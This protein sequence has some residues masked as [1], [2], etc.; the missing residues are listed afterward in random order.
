MNKKYMQGK[1]GK[2]SAHRAAFVG[3][4][5]Y[6][7]DKNLKTLSRKNLIYSFNIQL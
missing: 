1:R 2:Q 4:N 7:W 6:S 5:R 3:L